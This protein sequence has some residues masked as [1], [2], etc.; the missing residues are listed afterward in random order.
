MV[1]LLQLMI[2]PALKN[3]TLRDPV[4][5]PPTIPTNPT[6]ELMDV[7]DLSDHTFNQ[8]G[9]F[10]IVKQWTSITN[11]SIYG[12][13]DHSS[14]SPPFDFLAYVKSLKLLKSLVLYGI[15]AAS[16]IAYTLCQCSHDQETLLLN[17]SYFLLAIAPD[18]DL[19][20][21]LLARRRHQ[22]PQLQKMTI[23]LGYVRRLYDLNRIDIL[24]HLSDNIFVVADP[25]VGKFIPIEEVNLLEM[26]SQGE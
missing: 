2:I 14:D 7:D 22:L 25:E 24:R 26:L 11:L 20:R 5:Y 8:D 10:E 13:G 12:I 17:L 23:S 4:I 16:S 6:I 18:I 9:L 1:P 19:S 15:G 21:Y 3:L